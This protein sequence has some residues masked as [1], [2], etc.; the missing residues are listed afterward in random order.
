VSTVSQELPTTVHL[1]NQ[2]LG[3][4]GCGNV[5]DFIKKVL[6]AGGCVADK[7]GLFLRKF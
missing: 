1:G 5:Q 2:R 6:I 3:T 7:V 4:S